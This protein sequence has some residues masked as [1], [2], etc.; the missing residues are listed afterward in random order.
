MNYFH[1]NN[2]RK[3]P[4]TSTEAFPN[5]TDYACAVERPYKKGKL[6]QDTVKLIFIMLV[7]SFCASLIVTSGITQ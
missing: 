1:D 5:T 7:V 6:M 4:R 3:Y 2:T